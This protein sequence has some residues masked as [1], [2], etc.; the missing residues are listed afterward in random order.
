NLE[1]VDAA[2]VLKEEEE[3]NNSAK[4]IS[5]VLEEVLKEKKIR[6]RFISQEKLEKTMWPLYIQ[7][8]SVRRAQ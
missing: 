7:R 8:K 4:R 1:G 6:V 3:L 5:K 2:I